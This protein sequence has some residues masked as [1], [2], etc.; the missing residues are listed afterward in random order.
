MRTLLK[1]A[2]VILA[3]LLALPLLLVGALNTGPGQAGLSR[4]AGWASGGQVR[5]T[6]LA[7]RFPDRLHIARLE[8]H[9][10]DGMW[11][12]VDNA[13]LDW[14]PSAL[15]QRRAR[16]HLLTAEAVTVPRLPK[17]TAPS[18]TGSSP[19]GLPL[20]IELE[21]LAIARLNLGQPVA[22]SLALDGAARLETLAD[23]KLDL[24][25]RRLDA[26]GSYRL[27]GQVDARR[28]SADLQA[29]EPA[30]GLVASLAGL[31]DLG[32]LSVAA[33][34]DGPWNAA[35][36]QVKLAGGE[37]RAAADGTLDLCAQS[38][39]LAVTANAPAMTP[40][41]DISWQSVAID[42]QVRGTVAAPVGR[43]T[44]RIGGL[45]AVGAGADSIALDLSGD[46]GVADL[47]AVLTGLRLPGAALFAQAPVVIAARADLA[48]ATV[49]GTLAH[50]L[51]DSSF[52][53]RRDGASDV[54]LTLPELAPFAGLGGVAVAGRA[55]LEAAVN[56]NDGAVAADATLR[57]ALTDMPSPGMALLGPAPDVALAAT[58]R[59]GDVTLRLALTD[60]PSPGMALLGPAPD[61]ALAATVRGGDVTLRRLQ[62]N[63]RA[64]GVSARGTLISNALDAD[65][66]VDLRDVAAA[67]PALAGALQG[68]G[69]VAGP[70]DRLA[71]QADVSGTLGLH[72]TPPAPFT[73]A[74]RAE[75]LPAAPSATITV[76]GVLGGDRLSL[77]A[78]GSRAADG[79]LRLDV[80]QGDWKSAH[81][82]AR[83]GL[84]HGATLPSGT[85]TVRMGDLAELAPLIRQ[86][87]TG[88]I[89]A[90]AVFDDTEANV[91]V[92]G[93]RL[94]LPGTATAARLNLTARLRDLKA[95]VVDAKLVVDGIAAG[96][97]TG[98]AVRLDAAGPADALALNLAATAPGIRTAMAAKLDS[99]ASRLVISALNA[100]WRDER[101]TLAGPATLS[102]ADAVAVDHLRLRLRQASL[103]LAGRLS[104]TLDLTVALRDLPADLAAL[105]SPGLALAGS[106]RADARLTGRPAAPDGTVRIEATGLRQRSGPGASLPAAQMTANAKLAGGTTT[107]DANATV[108]GSRLAVA[109]TVVRNSLLNLRG[110][111][112]VDLALLDP[113]LA[114]DG[115]R[116][117]G[118]IGLDA[119][120]TGQT[121]APRIAGGLSLTRGEV[122]DLGQGVR[123]SDIAAR[124]TA[125]G[126]RVVLDSLTGRAGAGTI[127]ARGTLGL[128]G[129]MPLDFSLT[130]R[131]ASPVQ[132]ELVTTAIDAD[133]ALAGEL[134]GDKRASGTIRLRRTEIRIPEKL[135]A[136]V[137]VLNIRGRGQPAPPPTAP[138]PDIALD[139]AIEAP[140]QIFVRGRGLNAELGGSLRIRGTAAAPKPEGRF[141]LRRG[142]FS[143]VGK[144]LTFTQGA[145]GFDGHV[146]I[147]PTL[148]FQAT[149]SNSTVAATLTVGGYASQPKITLSSVP[150]L[151][152]DEVLAQLLFSKSATTLGPIE[153]AQ[154]AAALAQI[155]GVGGGAGG[156][157]DA[158]RGRLGLDRLAVGGSG[159]SGASVEAGRTVAK[160]VYVG[161]RQSTSGA[162]TQATVEID[163]AKGL[164][165][166]ADIGASSG[167]SATGAAGA[168]G[169]GVGLKYEFEY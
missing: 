70:L 157:L 80:T 106:L 33:K 97:T 128:A 14:S 101:L 168:G 130:A 18:T 154:I 28:L 27:T 133:L 98:A 152:Q 53:L 58:V 31:P 69:R 22:A 74:L 114:A 144:T 166:Q 47:R 72:G 134:S 145:V 81:A 57:L 118:R 61:V 108:G 73:A 167:S 149:S 56:R 5:I 16:V 20:P 63:G 151:P 12:S 77:A 86:R 67:V 85:A 65:W 135:P 7:G 42:A 26:P 2:V 55:V 90:H 103:D 23:G 163:I 137:A 1:V 123:I 48:A 34:V 45:S 41:A 92:Q 24:S 119:T 71:A 169:T 82:E 115:R 6:G 3:V 124:I 59:G 141:A 91:T 126:D 93:E 158:I 110:T 88:G 21:K 68:Q 153:L 100:Q 19:A 138:A 164:K 113:L 105:A 156:T 125:Q 36:V 102:Y 64:L 15:L 104:P 117:R 46:R 66:T 10:A 146:P 165:L 160:G 159:A 84:A 129:A 116:A 40:R 83:L 147:D 60:M 112:E 35:V 13:D 38:A 96:G 4:L 99:V 132:S 94:G 30:K 29:E 136:Q 142:E 89:D 54:T 51:A 25:V 148:D 161:A 111:G 76:Q 127:A 121:D 131:N 9:D 120:V 75:G 49:T 140:G 79:A 37:L 50:P 150:T 139:V 143:I 87:I 155:A 122:Q 62:V 107:L 17:S 52:T 11:M 95:P 32:A 43:G 8:V 162:G 109:G 78:A 44:V 39:D